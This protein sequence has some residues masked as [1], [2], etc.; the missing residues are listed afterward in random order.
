M[1]KIIGGI[2]YR[3]VASSNGRYASPPVENQTLVKEIRIFG[4]W[5][6]IETVAT[7][8]VPCWAIASRSMGHSEW[9]SDFAPF[10]SEGILPSVHP[11]YPIKNENI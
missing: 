4:L 5:I 3:V 1:N 11:N 6:R 8:D 2:R 9:V 7:E 10:N